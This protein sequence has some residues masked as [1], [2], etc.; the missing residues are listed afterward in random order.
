MRKSRVLLA[1]VAVAAA[2]AA[3][4]AFTASNTV[5]PTVAGYGEGAVSGATIDTIHYASDPADP[6]VITSV[7]FVSRSNVIGQVATMTLKH[8]T[9]DTDPTLLL[10]GGGPYACTTTGPMST[11]ATPVMDIVCSTAIDTNHTSAL[12]FADFDAVGLTVVP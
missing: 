6:S 5:P 1:G 2:A 4:S 11:A 7:T 8:K 10:N 9:S 3:T 12:H